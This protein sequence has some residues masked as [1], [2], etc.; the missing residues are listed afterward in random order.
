ML[1]MLSLAVCRNT[2]GI[3]EYP[4]SRAAT[5]RACHT[6]RQGWSGLSQAAFRVGVRDPVHVTM[7]VIFQYYMSIIINVN[8]EVLAGTSIKRDW[9]QCSL[10]LSL[11][12]PA[13]CGPVLASP[14]ASPSRFIEPGTGP[15]GARNC[16][17]LKLELL[18]QLLAIIAIIASQNF[19]THINTYIIEN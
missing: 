15:L 16:C 9:K 11:L 10:S 19:G 1:L 6:N 17:Q 4:A 7:S 8:E 12:S 14:A 18:L 2:Q 3:V 5:S 13:V